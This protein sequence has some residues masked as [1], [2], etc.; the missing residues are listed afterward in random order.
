[1]QA[2][3][4]KCLLVENNKGDKSLYCVWLETFIVQKTLAL[5]NLSV[6]MM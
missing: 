6:D 2:E 4:D 1:M 3:I 5:D